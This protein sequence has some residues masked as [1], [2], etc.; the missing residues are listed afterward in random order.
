MPI[1]V[2]LRKWKQELSAIWEHIKLEVT[3]GYMRLGQFFFFLSKSD[4]SKLPWHSFDNSMF[5][6]DGDGCQR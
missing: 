5:V 2:A 1:T 3:P 6:T 4:H